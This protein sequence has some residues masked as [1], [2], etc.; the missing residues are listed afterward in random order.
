MKPINRKRFAQF[1]AGLIT[2]LGLAVPAFAQES[3]EERLE[4]LER[5]NEQIRK[6]SETLQKQNE[7]L[8]KRLNAAPPA[9]PVSTAAPALTT[10]DVRQIITQ[11]QQQQQPQQQPADGAAAAAPDDRY[12]VGS[13]LRMN[14]SWQNGLVIST[15]NKDFS[16]HIGGWVQF[17]NVWWSQ[18]PAMRANPV[19][20]AGN[21]P[22]IGSGVAAGG[23]GNLQ[24]GEY[25]R[26]IRLQTDGKFWENYEY[27]LTLAF[28]NDQ[29]DTIGLDEF[30]VGATNIPIIGTARLGHVKNAIG[31]E[32]DMSGSSK[33]MTFMERSSYSEGIELNQNF[34]T[35]LWL[36]NNY[37]DQRATWSTT[38]FAPDQASATG[39]YFGDGQWGAQARLTALPIYFNEG[40]QLLHVALSGGYR[41]TTNN[42]NGAA[43]TNSNL[44]TITLQARPEMRDDDPAGGAALTPALPNADS[45]RMLSTGPIVAASDFL[46]GTEMLY[47]LGPLSI[48]GEYGFNFVNDASGFVSVGNAGTPAAGTFIKLPSAQNYTFSGGYIQ[49]AYTLTGENRA[50]DK[51][52][53][54]L[55]SWYFGRQGLR[56]NAWAVRDEDGRLNFNTGAWEIAARYSYLNLND[57]TGKSAIQGG[58][59]DGL[60]VGLNW[61]LNDN[62]KLQLQ[63]VYDNRYDVPTGT[64]PGYTSGF[65]IRMQF[66]Y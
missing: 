51:R 54:R 44:K 5:Q 48:Q 25:F 38:L 59:M 8:L 62:A 55:D 29:F 4:R 36:G 26:R 19:G 1:A 15:P 43:G 45:N 22:G 7:A 20:K 14:A 28:E 33:V 13:D 2:A 10:D 42:I 63:Y 31:I 21:Q 23:I 56:N 11:Y 58:I 46:L 30:W 60:T 65:G 66:S 27:T 41:A 37:F 53:G 40:R 50:Y 49:V 3:L 39:A 6:D 35:G 34:V 57:G 17:D 47:I 18:T 64:I 16:M 24:D 61:Y 32:A 52:L 12:K 9:M